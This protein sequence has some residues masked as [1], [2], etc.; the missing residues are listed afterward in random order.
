MPF[1][2]SHSLGQTLMNCF[3]LPFDS[4][5]MNS[6]PSPSP[7]SLQTGQA[8]YGSAELGSIPPSACFVS[9]SLSFFCLFSTVHLWHMEVPGVGVELELQLLTCTTATG[10]SD[11]S[12]DC[13]LHHSSLQRWIL[14]PLSEAR[15]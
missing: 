14:N 8:P 5:R 3:C 6:L 2:N 11:L 13:D 9:L 15:D 7:G 10:M 4:G 12:H 1:G